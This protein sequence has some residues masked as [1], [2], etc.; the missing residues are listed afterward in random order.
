MNYKFPLYSALSSVPVLKKSY[1]GKIMV[2]AF[3]GIHTPLLCIIT[4]LITQSELG[5]ESAVSILTVTLL[6]TLA[7]T[8]ATLYILIGLLKP[9]S[10]TSL[11]LRSYLKDQKLPRL[12]ENY[13]DEVGQLMFDVQY[14]VGELQGTITQLEK[15]SS[16]DSL[17]GAVNRMS[18][19]SNLKAISSSLNDGDSIY[20]AM[21][22]LDKFKNINDQYG[23]QAGDLCLQHLVNVINKNI[24][25]D[26]SLVRWG[27]D[28]FLL[29]LSNSDI[30]IAKATYQRLVD[31]VFDSSAK[32]SCGTEINLEASIGVVQCHK[33]F[34]V[35]ESIGRAD[36]MLYK[37]KK[38]GGRR[39]LFSF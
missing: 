28:E 35:D 33:G 39:V 36:E 21:I 4:F 18:A 2:V 3:V 27:G 7:G 15:L 12:P 9:V 24:R 10:V 37:A 13:H 29:M 38:E 19:E 31:S 5:F 30:E 23:H 25:K 8:A 14:A 32:L 22:D 34:D 20:I 1:V 17:T 26:D 11:A 6:A 16:T